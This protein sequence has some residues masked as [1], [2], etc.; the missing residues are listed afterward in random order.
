MC[1][2]GVL[3]LSPSRAPSLFRF[4]NSWLAQPNHSAP[5]S[6][7]RQ[8]W[9]DPDLGVSVV[10]R[11][12]YSWFLPFQPMPVPLWELPAQVESGDAFPALSTPAMRSTGT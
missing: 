6:H 11:G 5:L 1:G 9:E 8:A 4:K 2:D 3:H 12:P 7:P 10:H